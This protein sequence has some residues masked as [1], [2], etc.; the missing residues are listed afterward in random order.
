MHSRRRE[1]WQLFAMAAIMSGRQN[2]SQATATADELT[3]AYELR[4]KQWDAEEKLTEEA[5][6]VRREGL[7]VNAH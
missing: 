1:F 3:K 2:V 7:G 6:R 4:E 5:D